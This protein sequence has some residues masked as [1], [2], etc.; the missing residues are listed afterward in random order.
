MMEQTGQTRQSKIDVNRYQQ[1][2]VIALR[3]D[4]LTGRGFLVTTG[5]LFCAK[6][7]SRQENFGACLS[8]I[9]ICI[10]SF[11]RKLKLIN[12]IL[13]LCVVCLWLPEA[14]GAAISCP[15]S[16]V[17]DYRFFIAVTCPVCPICPVM[18]QGDPSGAVT[19]NFTLLYY[20][21]SGTDVDRPV[22]W[23]RLDDPISLPLN[24]DL[25]SSFDNIE[26]FETAQLFIAI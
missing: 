10:R 22:I 19:P 25:A 17:L 1:S 5:L 8:R 12:V 14:A 4:R 21:D 3:Q 23:G 20:A 26:Y 2:D 18:F 24:S 16:A 9:A 6:D 15:V 7:A 13:A 11:F